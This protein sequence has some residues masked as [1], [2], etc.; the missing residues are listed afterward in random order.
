[1][2]DLSR[3]QFT[4]Q[5]LGSLLTVSLLETLMQCDALADEIKPATVK[6][7]QD[8]NQL[9]WDVK[10]QKI[11]ELDWQKK[12]EELFAK[13]ELDD[14]LR[15]IDFEKLTAGVKLP[16]LGA[17]SLRIKFPQVEG[18][19]QK[20]AFGQQVFALKKGRSVVPHGHNN[21]ATAFLVLKG[22]FRGRNYDRIQ[23]EKEYMLIKPTVDREFGPGSC[24][25]ISDDKD[26][27]HWF[28]ALAEPAFIF[29]IH[30]MD[31]RPG[32]AAATGRVYVDPQGE[33]VSGGLIRA[34]LLEH[35]EVHKL[36]G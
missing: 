1:M 36:Y 31:V 10:G 11:K 13:V 5:A 24:S 3:R 19:P 16:D 25:T 8:V 33:R 15:L 29:N 4:Q 18:M 6:W 23:D 32:A 34:K 12:I 20:L 26:N 9:G 17:R 21:M 14:V 27:V 28:Q 2:T 30:V 22:N 35:D 7:F